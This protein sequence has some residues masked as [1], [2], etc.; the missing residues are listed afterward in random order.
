MHVVW[1]KFNC[2][3]ELCSKTAVACPAAPSPR[4]PHGSCRDFLDL[5]ALDSLCGVHAL[6][7]EELASLDDSAFPPLLIFDTFVLFSFLIKFVAS[8]FHQL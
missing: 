6:K 2:V 3:G 5:S 1:K 4:P 8:F 7:N